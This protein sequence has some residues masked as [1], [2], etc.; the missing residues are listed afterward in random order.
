MGA[1]TA[2]MVD[3]F[4][5]GLLELNCILNQSLWALASDWIPSCVASWFHF[6][7]PKYM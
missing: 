5:P 4:I 3:T 1:V 2:V 6:P 7:K